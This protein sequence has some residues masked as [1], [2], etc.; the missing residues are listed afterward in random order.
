MF[1]GGWESALCAV[2]IMVPVRQAGIVF[3][4]SFQI[5]QWQG[6]LRVPS[7]APEVEWEVAMKKERRVN[8]AELCWWSMLRYRNRRIHSQGSNHV[9]LCLFQSNA[10]VLN[11]TPKFCH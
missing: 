8:T 6:M 2:S 5:L 9:M 10:A 1:L 11:R 7:C 3:K 4:A